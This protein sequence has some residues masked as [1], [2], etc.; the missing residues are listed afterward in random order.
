MEFLPL[1]LA[2]AVISYVI[3]KVFIKLFPREHTR[4]EVL[5]ARVEQVFRWPDIGDYRFEVVGESNYQKAL[6]KYAGDHDENG[7][8]TECVAFIIPEDHNKYDD[9]AVRVDIGTDTVGYLSRDDARSFRRR[10]AAR[11]MAGQITSC[12]ALVKGGFTRNG[13]AMSYGIWLDIKEFE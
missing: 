2:L 10:L 7:S 9:K 12:N 13:E 8:D 6:K 11:K 5:R 1:I 4:P 3:K